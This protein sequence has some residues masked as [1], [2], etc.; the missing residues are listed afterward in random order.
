[1]GAVM[2]VLKHP[3]AIAVLGAVA[4]AIIDARTGGKATALLMKAPGYKT[5]AGV[6]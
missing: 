2:R 4:F 1:M 5:I 6:A 3:I